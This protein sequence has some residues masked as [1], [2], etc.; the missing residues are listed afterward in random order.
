MWKFMNIHLTYST[1]TIL[2]TCSYNLIVL[3]HTIHTSK[4]VADIT[5]TNIKQIYECHPL[6]I[7]RNVMS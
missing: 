3:E 4:F 2:M 7:T 1:G 6:G 5:Y